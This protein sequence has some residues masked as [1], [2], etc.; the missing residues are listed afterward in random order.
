V[1]CCLLFVVCCLLFV[2][3]CCLFVVCCLLFVVCCLLQD[4]RSDAIHSVDGAKALHNAPYRW[5]IC[6]SPVLFVVGC[7]PLLVYYP[8]N[9]Q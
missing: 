2:V 7:L 8:V 3:C 9:N 5:R 4:L 1:V 6:V